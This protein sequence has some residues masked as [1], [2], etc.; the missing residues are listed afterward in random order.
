MY[1]DINDAVFQNN[2]TV[3]VGIYDK[4]GQLLG[5]RAITSPPQ[6]NTISVDEILPDGGYIKVMPWGRNITPLANATRF[7]N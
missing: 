6:S 7:F 4:T 1:I 5:L 2:G 3:Y